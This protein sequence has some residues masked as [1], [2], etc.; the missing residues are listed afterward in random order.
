MVDGVAPR[1]IVQP[2][3]IHLSSLKAGTEGC[4][5]FPDPKGGLILS[6]LALRPE[7]DN[8]DARPPEGS[9][10]CARLAVWLLLSTPAPHRASP[11]PEVKLLQ[12]HCRRHRRKGGVLAP[13]ACYHVAS[14]SCTKRQHSTVLANARPRLVDA[15]YKEITRVIYVPILLCFAFDTAIETLCKS[16]LMLGG[17]LKPRSMPHKQLSRY[18]LPP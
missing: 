11:H 3:E 9:S 15:R 12:A 10:C 6:I 7:T 4:C 16:R 8:G 18:G 5:V 1:N 2:I 17:L 14:P 13:R